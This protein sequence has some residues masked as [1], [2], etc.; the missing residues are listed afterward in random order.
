MG[1]FDF[2]VALQT[3]HES[4][5][6]ALLNDPDIGHRIT[7]FSERENNNENPA[8]TGQ[9]FS[10]ERFRYYLNKALRKFEREIENTQLI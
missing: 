2:V 8:F 1:K 5:F 9:K 3:D 10:Q 6:F 7:I 4:P